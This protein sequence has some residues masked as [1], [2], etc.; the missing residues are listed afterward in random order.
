MKI[1]VILYFMI[2][3]PNAQAE[4]AGWL[5]QSVPSRSEEIARTVTDNRLP[6]SASLDELEVDKSRRLIRTPKCNIL[7]STV[8]TPTCERKGQSH[9]TPNKTLRKRGLDACK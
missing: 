1:S 9:P 8:T 7:E 2:F 6:S 3:L 4:G 5:A